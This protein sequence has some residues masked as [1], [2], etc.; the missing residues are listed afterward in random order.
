M[1]AINALNKLSTR[2]DNEQL[3]SILSSVL[4]KLRPCFEK[5]CFYLKQQFYYWEIIWLLVI[6]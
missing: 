4:L 6:I 2:V 5:V 1:E 3:N